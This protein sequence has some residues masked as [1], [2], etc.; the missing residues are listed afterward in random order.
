MF[1]ISSLVTATMLY[2]IICLKAGGI[3]GVVFVTL[4]FLFFITDGVWCRESPDEVSPFTE[5]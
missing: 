1:Q 3:A 2:F 5:H 4:M